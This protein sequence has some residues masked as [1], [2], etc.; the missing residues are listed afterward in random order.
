VVDVSLDGE[1]TRCLGDKL[2][3]KATWRRL[4]LSQ[5]LENV[6][7]LPDL[8]RA[9]VRQAGR[10]RKGRSEQRA[11]PVMGKEQGEV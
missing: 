2:S 1:R 8:G 9:G 10:G 6:K 3:W 5:Y 7:E 11:V 4:C